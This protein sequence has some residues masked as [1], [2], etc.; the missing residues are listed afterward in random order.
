MP[1][2]AKCVAGKH[3]FSLRWKHKMVPQ[4]TYGFVAW[5]CHTST[6]QFLSWLY[7]TLSPR[8]AL[9]PLSD[10]SLD[11]HFQCPL[12]FRA[13]RLSSTGG[14][15]ANVCTAPW[16]QPWLVILKVVV[17]VSDTCSQL[18]INPVPVCWYERIL[19]HMD[20]ERPWIVTNYITAKQSQC[21]RWVAS[22]SSWPFWEL[23]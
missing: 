2:F 12:L 11:D 9:L 8:T 17:L 14:L 23:C 19:L 1:V 21:Q 20:D 15:W 13:C 10:M 6:P 22:L 4:N 5:H 7:S 16:P 18:W 3:K